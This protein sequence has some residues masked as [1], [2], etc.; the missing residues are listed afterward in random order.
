M[1]AFQVNNFNGPQ[2]GGMVET[3]V[4]TLKADEVRV[5]LRAASVN[6]L[7]VKILAG[8]MESVFP[9]QFPYTPGTDFS[10]Q[11]EA[12]GA[13]V[14]ALQPGDR[15]VGRMEPGRGGAFAQQLTIKASDLCKIPNTMSF[16]QAAAL[17]TAYGT[18]HLALLRVANLRKNQRV[19]IHAGAGGVGSFAIQI[20]KQAGAYVIATASAA[21]SALLKE[22]GADEVIDYRTENFA[23]L[24]N[25]DVVLDSIGG[26]T[27]ER[28]WSVLHEV[29]IIATLA[30]FAIK[31]KGTKRGEFVFF[32]EAITAL[33]LAIEKFERG[34]LQ[35]LLDVIYNLDETRSALEKVA[36][37]HARGKVI[38]RM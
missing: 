7:D 35:I 6:P 1:K 3:P 18:A 33:P 17:P 16:E 2:S 13:E 28:S 8:Y 15:V 26:E 31:P 4:Q 20:A 29:G 22:L 21:N 24:N 23:S 14:T 5:S 32:K 9:V 30:D 10:G 25:I 38:V 12:V 27:L 11:V 34:Q 37:G 36:T 19:L